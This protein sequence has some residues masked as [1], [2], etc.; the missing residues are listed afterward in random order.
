MPIASVDPLVQST[1]RASSRRT[2]PAR[3][4]FFRNGSSLPKKYVLIRFDDIL[5]I[6]KKA[7]EEYGGNEEL[8]FAYCSLRG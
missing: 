7:H 3:S 5:R 2:Q 8:V 1:R 4:N 6:W